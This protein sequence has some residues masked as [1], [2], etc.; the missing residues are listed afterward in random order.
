[1]L[2]PVVAAQQ[3]LRETTSSINCFK[4]SNSLPIGCIMK[5]TATIQKDS[6]SLNWNFFIPVTKEIA[7]HFIDKDRRV[8]CKVNDTAPFHAAL[9]PN[10]KG[11]F[12]INLNKERRKIIG[13]EIGEPIEVALEKD[14][15]KYGMPMPAEMEELL[16]LDDEGSEYFHALTLGKQRSLLH[17]VGK[18]KNSDTRIKKAIVIVEYLKNSKGKLDFK[19]LN[20]AFKDYNG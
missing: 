8:I 15:S 9:M 14:E 19:E 6:S 16:A 5:F 1:M 2:S 20:Q 12:F 4:L 13:T 18:P 3:S 10:G 17:L 11:D 7:Q